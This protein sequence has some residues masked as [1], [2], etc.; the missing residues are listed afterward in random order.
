MYMT[1]SP[2]NKEQDDN[3]NAMTW[4]IAAFVLAWIIAGIV[5]FFMSILCFAYSGSWIE[6]LGGFLIAILFGPFYWIYYAFMKTYCAQIPT[7]RSPSPRR[8]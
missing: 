3:N 1:P 6:K 5:A 8:R 2:S 4:L 7:K